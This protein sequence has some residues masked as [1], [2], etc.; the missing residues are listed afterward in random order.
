[1]ARKWRK[2]WQL[3]FLL[4]AAR[5]AA[6]LTAFWTRFSLI[7]CRVTLPLR[8]STDPQIRQKG[9]NILSGPV[10]QRFFRQKIGKVFR[11]VHV[12]LGTIGPNPVFLRARPVGFPKNIAPSGIGDIHDFHHRN[13]LNVKRLA[14]NK[15]LYNR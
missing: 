6:S 2:V 13:P 5:A 7:W 1:V 11:P 8:G 14:Q 9:F 10:S 15:A 4:I 12:E 3:T